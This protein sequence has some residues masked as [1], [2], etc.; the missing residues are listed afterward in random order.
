MPSWTAPSGWS[1]GCPVPSTNTMGSSSTKWPFRMP[2]RRY[3]PNINA[4]FHGGHT[5][6]RL[7]TAQSWM[8]PSHT[9]QQPRTHRSC[10]R[11]PGTSPPCAA[12]MPSWL[13]PCF[14]KEC[15]SG[16]SRSPVQKPD[17]SRSEEHTSELQSLT[18]LVCRLLLEKKKKKKN[19]IQKTKKKKKKNKK[20]K[21]I[22]KK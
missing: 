3:A 12:T 19:K 6:L 15:R 14:G 8:G 7:L 18:N 5:L 10:A 4:C 16:L 22:K 17:S 13:C 2:R 21:K 11:A 9:L 1:G 20:K